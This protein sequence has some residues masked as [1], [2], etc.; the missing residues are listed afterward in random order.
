MFVILKNLH[1]RSI[2]FAQRLTVVLVLFSI[3]AF[4]TDYYV[5]DNSTSGDAFT[6]TG[7][8]NSNAGTSVSDPKLTLAN[9]LSTHGASLTY[10]D[11]IYIDAGTY[12]GETD[13]TIPASKPGI[14]FI[15]AGYDLTIIDNQL[16]GAATAFFMYIKASNTSFSNMSIIGYENNGTQTPGHSAQAITIDGTSG[17]PVTGVLFENV[18]FY[19]NGASGGN[20]ALS[21]LSYAKVTLRGGGSYCNSPGK[22][23]TGGVELYGNNNTLN[24]ED[25]ILS[26][27]DK[28]LFDG[29]GLRIEGAN[30][31]FVN[32]SNTR[33]SNNRGN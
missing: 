15:G 17:S 23:Y 9:L 21:V 6:T 3:N 31:S 12:N 18:S 10:G 30:T 1:T 27:N 20:P 7:G 32:V 19:N 26:G 28:T 25:Y 13:F 24:I 8:S 5:N 4:S 22:A 14:S 33:I 29:G 16:A 11:K 2:P